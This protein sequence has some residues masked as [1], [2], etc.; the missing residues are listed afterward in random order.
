MSKTT[1]ALISGVVGIGLGLWIAQQYATWKVNN[2]IA[3]GLGAVG[4]GAAAP[5]ADKLAAG[6]L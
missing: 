2:A 3:T 5:V 6:L 4:L 1:V